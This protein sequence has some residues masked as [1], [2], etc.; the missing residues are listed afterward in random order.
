VPIVFLDTCAILDIPRSFHREAVSQMIVQH[1]LSAIKALSSV[2]TKLHF[3]LTEQVAQEYTKNLQ[4]VLNELHTRISRV[5]QIGNSL[6]QPTDSAQFGSTLAS[7]E[8]NLI[9]LTNQIYDSSLI[10]ATDQAC[11][12]QANVRLVSN[13]A[14]AKRGSTNKGDCL[15]IEHFL[16]IVRQLR[17]NG[18]HQPCIFVSSNYRDF[19]TAPNAKPPLDSEFTAISMDYM[20]D[21]AAALTQLGF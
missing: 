17:S 20:P 21:I 1:S 12:S 9:T 3:I 11:L 14:P 15:V 6:L 13:V 7:L 2:H 19:G 18:F 4:D 16:E 8:T 5:S 10:I